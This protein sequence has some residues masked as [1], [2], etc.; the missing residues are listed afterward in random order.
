MY[1]YNTIHIL[2]IKK[3]YGISPK[4]EKKK[5]VVNLFLCLDESIK[6]MLISWVSLINPLIYSRQK[7]NRE[8]ILQPN[9]N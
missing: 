9:F 6:E 8:F 5:S 2:L 7:I 4:K 3:I 1:I